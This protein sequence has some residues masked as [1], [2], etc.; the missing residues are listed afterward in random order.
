MT[1]W[2]NSY[3]APS[4]SNKDWRQDPGGN[5][6]YIGGNNG[7]NNRPSSQGRLWVC[8]GCKSTNHSKNACSTCGMRRSWAEMAR[9]SP[10]SP[11]PVP[12][13]NPVSVKLEQVA[14]KLH[15]ATSQQNTNTVPSQQ[16]RPA[17]GGH[18]PNGSISQQS[19]RAAIQAS[20][21]SMENAITALGGDEFATC[22]HEL[23]AKIE[24]KKKELTAA[25]PMGQ[26]LDNTRAAVLR[27]MKRLEQAREAAKL[28]QETLAAAEAETANLTKELSEL[29]LEMAANAGCE[30]SDSD[31][32]PLANL[33]KQLAA[34]IAELK[35][36]G[37]V[38]KEVIDDASEQA[39]TLLSRFKTTIHV[40]KAVARED[41]GARLRKDGKQPY[42]AEAVSQPTAFRIVGKQHPKRKITDFFGPMKKGKAPGTQQ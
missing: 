40:A 25:R 16:A 38:R 3:S 24:L 2:Q 8:T 39:A 42:Q 27:S 20:I 33:E 19:D 31:A 41:G 9:N 11:T 7:Q 28:A 18:A 29:E 14:E 15:Q 13:Q 5:W 26:R 36:A 6:H 32:C 10:S 30:P 22:R 21:K 12:S 4:Y 17:D 23:Q 34:S 35:N 1:Q 37:N